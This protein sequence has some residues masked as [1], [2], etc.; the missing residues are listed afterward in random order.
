MKKSDVIYDTSAIVTYGV[1]DYG[2]WL[3]VVVMEELVAGADDKRRIQIH[4]RTMQEYFQTDHLL[5]PD[6]EDWF[7]AGRILN[8]ILRNE[9][10]ISR[11]KRTPR[12]SEGQKQSLIRDVL[13]ART[14]K[15]KKLTV[16]SDNKDF[17][18]IHRYYEFDWI[19]GK[20]FFN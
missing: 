7:E 10:R 11:D 17:P 15:R 13:I 19:S 6:H 1:R 18:L 2:T 5:V 12:F 14:A 3:S 20:E 9:K 16:V 8:T 4:R